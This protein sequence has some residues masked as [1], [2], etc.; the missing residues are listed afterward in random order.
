MQGNVKQWGNS[1]AI[2]IPAAIIQAAH[3]HLN[4]SVDIREEEGRIIIEPTKKPEFNLESLL[5]G[6]TQ[7]NV[8]VESDFGKPVG[9]ELW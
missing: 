9:N 2:R 1:A 8:H 7:A 4:Q 5:S 3:L 6:I